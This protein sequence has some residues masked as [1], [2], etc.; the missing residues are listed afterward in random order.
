M[1]SYIRRIRSF[2]RDIRLF[3][4]FSLLVTTGFGV[5]GLVMNLYLVQ[6]GL[7]EDFI[8]IFSAV[9]TIAIAAGA[10][11]IG[12]ALR[13][14]TTWQALLFG[15]AGVL[16]LQVALALAE[17]EILLLVLAALYGLALAYLTTVT[18]PFI[19]E[20]SRPGA[21][22]Q[23]ASIAFALNAVAA[24]VGSLL[25]GYVPE[26]TAA[27]T[28]G[29]SA[30]VTGY[31]VALLTG[32]VVGVFAL[33][34]LLRMREAR[35]GRGQGKNRAAAPDVPVAERRQTRKDVSVYVV[36]G[37][38][39]A[40]GLGTVIPFYP[41]FLT[42]NGV[43]PGS[44]GIIYAMGN[45]LG[46]GFSLLGPVLVQRYGNLRVNF[47]I[48]FMLAP[49]Y[50]LLLLFPTTGVVIFAH[51]ARAVSLNMGGPLD[52]TF[53]ADILPQRLQ[54]SAIGFRTASWNLCWAG[55]S[56]VGGWV[57]VQFGYDWTFAAL[58]I[59]AVAASVG[60][61][62]YWS[63][64]PR[65][66]SGQI[67]NALTQKQRNAVVARMAGEAEQ[68]ASERTDEIAREEARQLIGDPGNVDHK[69]TTSTTV[70]L[71]GHL[72]DELGV[73]LAGLTT[74]PE[75]GTPATA[76]H[77]GG[78]ASA[79]SDSHGDQPSSGRSPS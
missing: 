70:D 31:R 25:G 39:L 2:N 74:E 72:A 68:D 75:D 40:L 61:Y 47:S 14:I 10:I 26:L 7:R 54:A 28:G 46:A 66:R 44:V 73:D 12:F 50:L 1:R 57:I 34:P 16:V 6:L 8:G 38:V 37:G 65:V 41:V 56:I 19:I 15:G 63:R 18:M 5:F 35:Q 13:R 23:T 27:V 20:W 67:L 4:L 62:L 49:V 33:I 53:V 32:S 45:L 3:F 24:T 36:L 69:R 78:T 77:S 11:S 48:R 52:S 22:A 58:I 42:L 79:D 51:F 29:E 30:S 43:S 76:S 71:D 59:S 21:R 55:S 17:Q 9:N 60:F 64:H